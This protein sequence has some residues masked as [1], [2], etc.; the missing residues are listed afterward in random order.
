MVF[1]FSII[2]TRIDFFWSSYTDTKKVCKDFRMKSYQQV[3]R[4]PG[5]SHFTRVSETLVRQTSGVPSDRSESLTGIYPVNRTDSQST[6]WSF[7][8]YSLS[9]VPQQTLTTI[10]VH[11]T[12][13]G[14][15]RGESWESFSPFRGRKGKEPIFL[16]TLPSVL[17]L[18]LEDSGV[19]GI[20]QRIVCS[21][22]DVKKEVP[23]TSFNSTQCISRTRN[24]TGL[25]FSRLQRLQGK[26][27]VVGDL[28]GY[29]GV[30]RLDSGDINKVFRVNGKMYVMPSLK[31][32]PGNFFPRIEVL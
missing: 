29:F 16:I 7:H 12:V 24:E 31:Y 20:P 5:K 3:R 6:E 25:V 9:G 17:V 30:I 1:S 13:C 14:N 23:F 21:E 10:L 19:G 28:Q 15:N 18:G 32:Y 26:V 2:M 27:R 8:S 4:T 11:P 22:K